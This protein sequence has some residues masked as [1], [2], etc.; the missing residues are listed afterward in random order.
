MNRAAANDTGAN[1]PARPYRGAMFGIGVFLV[2][3][4]RI[5]ITLSYSFTLNALF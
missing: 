5:R 3:L 1:A 2:L 4:G